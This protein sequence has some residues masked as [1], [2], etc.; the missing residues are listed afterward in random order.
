M[1]GEAN[2]KRIEEQFDPG[3]YLPDE[4]QPQ[5]TLAEYNLALIARQLEKRIKYLE[6]DTARMH[7]R[8]DEVMVR[9]AFQ[10]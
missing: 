6:E 3:H 10:E 1:K 8:L 4:G 5:I 7:E 2:L 9:H